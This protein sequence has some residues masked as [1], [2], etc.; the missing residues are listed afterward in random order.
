[1]DD[2]RCQ[3]MTLKVQILQTL[4]RLFVIL[5]WQWHDLVKKCLFSIYADVVWCPTWLKNLERYLIK[6]R[7]EVHLEMNTDK[8]EMTM[9]LFI[10]ACINATCLFR[11]KV[12]DAT[13]IPGKTTFELKKSCRTYTFFLVDTIYYYF[14]FD[15]FTWLS[16]KG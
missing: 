2:S 10:K 14:L 3:K 16:A 8:H 4:K 9:G 6:G 7:L 11:K 5:V 13:T 12:F 15:L 1:M